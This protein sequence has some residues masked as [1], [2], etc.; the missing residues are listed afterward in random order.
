MGCNHGAFKDPV[1]APVRYHCV[2]NYMDHAFV[3]PVQAKQQSTGHNTLM[4]WV[5]GGGGSAGALSRVAEELPKELGACEMLGL[6]IRAALGSAS[7]RQL[8]NGIGYGDDIGNETAGGNTQEATINMERTRVAASYTLV[9]YPA[10]QT[11]GYSQIQPDTSRQSFMGSTP[12]NVYG[13]DWLI[14]PLKPRTSKVKGCFSFLSFPFLLDSSSP[15]S[16]Q[17]DKHR[18]R[19]RRLQTGSGRKITQLLTAAISPALQH[20]DTRYT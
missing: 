12:P 7:M 4:G 20:T 18:Y 2:P 8:S 13:A 5:G 19:Y 3:E 6:E 16:S 11:W 15:T 17:F 10:V 1:H 9:C 14:A